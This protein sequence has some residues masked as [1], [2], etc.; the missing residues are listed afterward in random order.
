M[1]KINEGMKKALQTSLEEFEKMP[2]DE[3]LTYYGKLQTAT[4]VFDMIIEHIKA[5]G[6]A[7]KVLENQDA[8]VRF[9]VAQASTYLTLGTEIGFSSKKEDDED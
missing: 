5:Y 6:D 9:V 1:S 2:E 8:I 4:A 3:K 7:E